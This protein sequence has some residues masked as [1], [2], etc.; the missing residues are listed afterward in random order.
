[1]S[2]KGYLVSFQEPSQTKAFAGDLH[3]GDITIG[4]SNSGGEN[5]AGCNLI[6]NPYASG[7][8][9]NMADRSLFIDDFA[10]VYDRESTVIGITEGYKTVDGS[11]SGAWIAPNQGF[12]VIKDIIGTASISFTNS[13]RGHGGVF[14]KDASADE[15]LVL[16]LGNDF[17]YDQATL[18]IR[19]NASFAHDRSDAMKFYSLNDNMPQ[20]YSYTSD[21]VKVALNSIPA[22]DEEK[23]IT[24]GVRIPADGSYTLSASEISGRFQSSPI[25]LLNNKS[26]DLHNFKE[27]PKYSFQATEGDEPA[28]FEIRF[29][30]PTNVP[31][32]PE[33]DLTHIYTHGQTLYITF[34][35]GARGRTLEVFDIIGRRQLHR[36]L[37]N[38]LQ[39]AEQLNLHPGVYIVRITGRDEEK[40]K[41]IFVE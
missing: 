27:N 20:V 13:M 17:Y 19:D 2:G 29:T 5:Y 14:S 40:T 26:G 12:F 28:M 8:D 22:I 30:Q 25:Y 10:Y 24:L 33:E 6:G 3:A 1:L 35:K 36:S 11:T 23:V 18:R 41:R 34:G 9:W 4:V 7:I 38:A 21:Q 32:E 15:M 31:Q 16:Q 37:G 39:F